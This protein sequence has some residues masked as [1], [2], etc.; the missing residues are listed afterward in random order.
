MLHKKGSVRVP[1]HFLIMIGLASHN[2]LNEWAQSGCSLLILILIAQSC[3]KHCCIMC[4]TL[5]AAARHAVTLFPPT[6]PFDVQVELQQDMS[7]AGFTDPEGIEFDHDEVRF[8]L[9]LKNTNHRCQSSLSHTTITVCTFNIYNV[10]NHD[11]ISHVK[12][13]ERPCAHAH[14]HALSMAYSG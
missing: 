2:V 14:A 3:S 5:A 4:C 1:L 7:R 11:T 12:Q 8:V 6:F 10:H 9:P 13:Q